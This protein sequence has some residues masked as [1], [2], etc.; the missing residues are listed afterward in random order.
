ML[1]IRGTGQGLG[2]HYFLVVA[3][4][5]EEVKAAGHC[6]NQSKGRDSSACSC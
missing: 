5:L 2:A 1:V 3:A 6:A 4:V